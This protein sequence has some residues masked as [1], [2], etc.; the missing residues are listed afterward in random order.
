MLSLVKLRYIDYDVT[1][2]ITCDKEKDTMYYPLIMGNDGIYYEGYWCGRYNNEK[3][4]PKCT[5]IEINEEFIKR[6]EFLV[7]HYSG[8][9][10]L[11]LM[12]CQICNSDLGGEVT[13]KIRGNNITYIFPT[14]VLHYYKKHQVLPSEE[15]YHFIMRIIPEFFKQ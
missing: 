14:T 13:C 8:Q 4:F 12:S 1:H 5:N 6:I 10:Y 2:K 3:P 11:N 15:F 9:L 7:K